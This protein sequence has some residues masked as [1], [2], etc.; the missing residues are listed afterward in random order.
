MTFLFI[1]KKNYNALL[2]DAI[3]VSIGIKVISEKN[4]IEPSIN[5]CE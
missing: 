4:Q 1:K 5:L 3:Y 2:N